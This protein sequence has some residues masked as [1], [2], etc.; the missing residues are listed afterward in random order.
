MYFPCKHRPDRFDLFGSRIPP[1]PWSECG[2]ASPG[3]RA[4]RRELNSISL[5]RP[6][7]SIRCPRNSPRTS[8]SASA[9][10]SVLRHGE[11]FV[12]RSIAHQPPNRCRPERSMPCAP[13]RRHRARNERTSACPSRP[14]VSANSGA[15]IRVARPPSFSAS[16]V[17]TMVD[18]G[19]V[20]ALHT[21]RHRHHVDVQ[22]IDRGPGSRSWRARPCRR[23][24][25]W[26]LHPGQSSSRRFPATVRR[27]VRGSYSGCR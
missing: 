13:R 11:R 23:R 26:C 18:V 14:S 2:A 16:S 1:R 6:S 12:D 15:W 27:P 17:A 10:A 9:P 20:L 4:T 5:T 24:S 21:P 25:R 3:G 19:V 7:V 8:L 22:V